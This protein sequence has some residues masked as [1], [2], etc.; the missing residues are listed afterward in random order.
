MP[1]ETPPRIR[2]DFNELVRGDLVLLSQSDRAIE[3][4]GREVM[5]LEGMAVVAFEENEYADGTAECLFAVGVA[6]RNDPSVN[7]EW[8]KNAKWCCRFTGGIQRK[9]NLFLRRSG[10]ERA[11]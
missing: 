8:T 9:D 5:L 3:A 4:D 7:G 10:N 11:T 1:L 6:E 2:V